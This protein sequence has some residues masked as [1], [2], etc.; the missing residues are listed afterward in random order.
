M[1]THCRTLAYLL[2]LHIC[3]LLQYLLIR[4]CSSCVLLLLKFRCYVLGSK[5]SR[6]EN[7]FFSST[8]STIFQFFIVHSCCFVV[9]SF[10]SNTDVMVN[11]ACKKITFTWRT[12]VKKLPQ[13]ITL[14]KERST[15]ILIFFGIIDS[16]FQQ[17]RKR[18]G[19]LRKV[20]RPA[21]FGFFTDDNFYMYLNITV[22][23]KVLNID[24]SSILVLILIQFFNKILR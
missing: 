24:T 15:Y 1:A 22:E 14:F 2:R 5:E 8:H 18:F 12:A 10:I 21:Q 20:I 6:R 23:L 13:I 19:L 3:Y 11:S 7:V 17:P 4:I 9:E 16:L